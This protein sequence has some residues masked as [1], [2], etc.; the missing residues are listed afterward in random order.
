[1]ASR[2]NGPKTPD[3]L[4]VEKLREAGIDPREAVWAVER[5]G[6]VAAWVIEHKYVE[7]LGAYAGVE[8][9][10][11]LRIEVDQASSSAWLLVRGR[12]GDREEWTTGE[13]S[14]TS[15]GK[16]PGQAYPIAMAE[17]RAKD[18]LILKLVGLHGFAYSSDEAEFE[19]ERV[20]LQDEGGAKYP[21]PP[22][23]EPDNQQPEGQY[24]PDACIAMLEEAETLEDLQ[25]LAEILKKAPEYIRAHEGVRKAYSDMKKRLGG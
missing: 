25:S 6:R 12:L 23:P 15:L 18:R 9:D 19:G 4:V 2:G 16:G 17:K 10:P 21:P 13:A 14:P 22:E 7:R 8:I 5:K 11:P 20:G 24:T 1:M 3:P